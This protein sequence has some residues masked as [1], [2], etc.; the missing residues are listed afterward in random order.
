MILMD[1]PMVVL[2]HP[3]TRSHIIVVV[4]GHRQMVVALLV[5][6]YHL[7]PEH[8]QGEVAPGVQPDETI[9]TATIHMAQEE[10]V[11]L[12]A[13]VAAVEIL[14]STID[15]PVAVQTTVGNT[16]AMVHLRLIMVEVPLIIHITAVE[17][18]LCSRLQQDQELQVRVQPLHHTHH[19]LITA[20]E[21]L[22]TPTHTDTLE[23]THPP[24]EK[25]R[26]LPTTKTIV[27][28]SPPR[29]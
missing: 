7:L 29:Q 16:I 19:L 8:H 6:V 1:I 14:T 27:Q 5:P 28:Q 20:Y 23:E 2:R 17:A 24:V 15:I 10:E 22:A 12:E 9:H 4:V 21:V 13:A 11:P 3:I 26:I 25:E 18:S